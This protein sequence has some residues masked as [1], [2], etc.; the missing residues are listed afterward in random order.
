MKVTL[1]VLLSLVAI[2]VVLV[3]VR[4]SLLQKITRSTVLKTTG[5]DIE[6]GRLHAGILEPVFEVSDARLINPEDFPEATA[7]EIRT[8]RVGYDLRSVLSDEIHLREVVV[9]VPRAVLV[10]REDGESN[11]S[12]L[13]K[14]L[15]E[16]K[17]EKEKA[18]GQ[19]PEGTPKPKQEK[20]ARRIRVDTLA[21]K[22][23]RVEMRRYREGESRPEVKTYDVNFERIATDVTDL[24]TINAMIIAGVIETVGGQALRGLGRVF[25]KSEGDLEKVGEAIQKAADKLTERLRRAADDQK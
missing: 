11:L 1:K 7:L 4:N 10:I 17:E 23:G 3:L 20:P 5:F 19:E 9:D 21:L 12:R 14:T 6:I 15:E 25:E 18:G 22:I 8:L 13:G 2:A 16:R 24:Q